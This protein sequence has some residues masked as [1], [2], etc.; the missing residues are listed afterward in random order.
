MS[1]EISVSQEL[2]QVWVK[3]Q[4]GEFSNVIARVD[5]RIHFDRN[6]A[7]S[8]G[9]VE[10]MIDISQLSAGSFVDINSVSEI[11]VLSWALAAQGGE[12]F[13]NHLLPFHSERLDY[14]EKQV[15]LVP[16]VLNG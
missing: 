9:G 12:N 4:Q 15:G 13:I 8:T 6:E 14:L 7:R 10:T 5:W 3:P 11:Q 1:G 16:Y 2:V